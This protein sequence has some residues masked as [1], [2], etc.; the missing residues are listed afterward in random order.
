MRSLLLVAL[1]GVGLSAQADLLEVKCLQCRDPHLHPADYGNF[2]F[3]QVFGAEGWVTGNDR[4]QMLIT[5]LDDRW[6]V[7]ELDHKLQYT[8][9]TLNLNF[10]TIDFVMISPE[11]VITVYADTGKHESYPTQVSGH[12]LIVGP[13]PPPNLAPP[14]IEQTYLDAPVRDQT[15]SFGGYTYSA[16]L[17]NS[18]NTEGRVIVGP[19]Y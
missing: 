12:D 15:G 5:N 1:F 4:G 13:P 7:V 14:S 19:S 3:N 9:F 2:A 16:P 6:A 11:I 10:I 17:T 8:P 18:N